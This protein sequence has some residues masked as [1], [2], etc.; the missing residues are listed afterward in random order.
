M[1]S[2]QK[3]SLARVDLN[4]LIVLDLLLKE[5]HV[6]RVADKMFVSQPAISRSLKKLREIFDDPL[7][8]RSAT[9]LSPTSKALQLEKE[10]DG[11]LPLL[12]RM[13]N[14]EEFIESKCEDTFS[15]SV[16]PFIG[17]V[18]IPDLYQYI[19]TRAPNV[20]IKEI[21]T[22][23]NALQLLDN[24]QLDF[25]FHYEKLKSAKY[26]SCYI[27]DLYPML[28]VRKGHPLLS[29]D[30]PQLSQILSYPVIG[31]LIEDDS[32]Q[33]IRMPILEVLQ[34]LIHQHQ[35]PRL[36]TVQT[37]NIFRALRDSDSVLFGS[38]G[39]HLLPEFEE[40]FVEIY[41][42]RDEPKYILPIY[43]VL[44]SRNKDNEAHKW[45]FEI[46]K[47]KSTSILAT[48]ST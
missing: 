7:F 3:T 31:N 15:L 28:F 33:S 35:K 44:H 13:L 8:T 19:Q 4:L 9:G 41:S 6:S 38:N 17:A 30:S 25:A 45:L 2:K 20:S 5:R 46:I 27:G 40:D 26:E 39:L 11:V 37:G 10:L 23:S 18:L 32:N 47:D 34:D 14:R 22:R 43:L 12:S 42:L 24:N 21:T 48:S 16:P 1:S 36:R 29:V